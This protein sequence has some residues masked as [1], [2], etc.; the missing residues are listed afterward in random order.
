MDDFEN[1]IQDAAEELRQTTKLLT[2]PPIRRSLVG[3]PIRWTAFA[4]GVGAVLV[5]LVA[6]PTLFDGRLPVGAPD[7]TV[8]GPVPTTDWEP[9]DPTVT[10]LPPATC[11]GTGA[12]PFV[13]MQELPPAV[14]QTRST[15][16]DD[17]IMCRFPEL[18][19]LAGPGFTTDFGGGGAEM[20][21][22]WEAAG[23]GKLGILAKIL[24]MTPVELQSGNGQTYHA[25]PSAFAYD[26]WDDI[27]Q[28][29]LDE[30]LAIYTQAE[31][32]ELSGFGSYAG[33][34]TGIDSE[35]NWMFFVAGD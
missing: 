1:R 25:W 5:A 10:T 8:P 21:A 15:I 14:A 4:V 7:T 28:A 17:A 16:I 31:L 32:D 9:V 34:R 12:V 20:F 27:P 23:E 22:E 19:A 11:S 35:G 2:P 6:V 18:T 29:A 26:S 30:L 33:W 3:I 24:N 13:A